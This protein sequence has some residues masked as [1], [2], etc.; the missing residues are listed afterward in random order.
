MKLYI[1]GKKF[2]VFLN[3]TEYKMNVYSAVQSVIKGRK[4]VLSDGAELKDINGSYITLEGS[5]S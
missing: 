4:I 2:K 1:N 5:E 3:N